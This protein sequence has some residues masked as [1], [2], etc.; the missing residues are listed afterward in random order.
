MYSFKNDYSEGCHPSLLKALADANFDQQAGYGEDVYS[1]AARKLICEK[2]ENHQVKISFVSGGTQANALVIASALRPYESVISAETG[3]INVHEAGA[4]EATGHKIESVPTLD[5]K[6]RPEDV[7][8]VLQKFEDHHMTKPRLVYISNTTEVGSIYSKS[9]LEQLYQYCQQHDL[10]VFMDGARLG[11]ALCAKD[12]DVTL[13]DIARW[14]DVFYIG[15]TKNGAL[16]GEA[17]VLKNESLQIDFDFHLKQRGALLSKGR[18]L[19][20]QFQTLFE[21]DLYFDLARHANAMAMKMAL[22]FQEKGYTFLTEP[23]SNQLFPILPYQVIEKLS[24]SYGFYI[25]K[26]IDSEKSAI[27][28]VTSW[29]TPESVVDQFITDLKRL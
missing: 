1:E 28:L 5:G 24:T 4:I 26:K 20:I 16:A 14:T 23:V 29:A 27:R 10:Y 25:W 12:N 3:H 17:L 13:A 22:A 8:S 21:N 19:G 11:S 2:I 18:F 15:G 9:E 7:H 6:L